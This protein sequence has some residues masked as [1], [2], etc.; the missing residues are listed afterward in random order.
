[1]ELQR[2][3]A[4]DSR[5]AT[6]IAAEKFGRDALIVSNERINGKVELIVAVTT[7][8]VTMPS[9]S[10]TKIPKIAVRSA[11]HPAAVDEGYSAESSTKSSTRRQT[12]SSSPP[13]TPGR[14]QELVDFVKSELAELRREIRLS[15]KLALSPLS[16]SVPAEA[17]PVFEALESAG[18]P[19]GARALLA[20]SMASS[21]G[22]TSALQAVEAALASMLGDADPMAHMQGI[23]ALAG[24]SG[25]GKT[26]MT[27]KLAHHHVFK[28]GYD[29]DDIAIVSFGQHGPGAW[30]RQQALASMVGIDC[31]LA[32]TPEVL[33]EVLLDLATRKLVLIDL[34]GPSMS[35]ALAQLLQCCP[36]AICHAVIPADAGMST[37]R[38]F[39]PA[40]S[41]CCQT[42]MLSKTD[43][44]VDPWSLLQASLEMG[45]R[46]SCNGTGPRMEDFQ[47]RW[48]ASIVVAAMMESIRTAIR[49]GRDAM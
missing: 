21:T 36:R 40:G 39:V 14:A 5:T 46:V 13:I 29:T 12:A 4:K 32:K 47:D 10:G 43:D 16:F 3:V 48:S 38:K 41:G 20:E 27:A 18:V 19:A 8:A 24:P 31:F 33:Q 6:A 30:G 49:S 17:R 28:H 45:L 7:P 34:P 22:E 25:G 2:I 42:L 9:S 11:A 26:L 44:A 1:M 15:Q 35:Q 23:H 37:F